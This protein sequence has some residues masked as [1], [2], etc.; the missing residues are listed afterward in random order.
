MLVAVRSGRLSERAVEPEQSSDPFSN[1]LIERSV[2]ILDIA[3]LLAQHKLPARDTLLLAGCA[4]RASDSR[5]HRNYLQNIE[6]K[7][8]QGKYECHA[9]WVTKSCACADSIE[10]ELKRL[11]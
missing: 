6:I 4:A 7:R 8:Q 3:L 2:A 5:W 9:V 11:K 1:L 10:M